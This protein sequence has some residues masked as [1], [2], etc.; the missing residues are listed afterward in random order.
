M[1]NTRTTPHSTIP[2]LRLAVA[3]PENISRLWHKEDEVSN[4]LLGH[5]QQLAH[6]RGHHFS[7]LVRSEVGRAY[8]AVASFIRSARAWK[9]IY[10]PADDAMLKSQLRVVIP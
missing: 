9:L 10:T 8:V 4:L 7:F 2:R 1:R 5:E 3:T 6:Q